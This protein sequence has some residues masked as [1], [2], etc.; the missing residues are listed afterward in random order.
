MVCS[1]HGPVSLLL[2][3]AVSLLNETSAS[4]H[5][6]RIVLRQVSPESESIFDLIIELYEVCRGDW[7]ALAEKAG[8]SRESLESFL[9]YSATFLDSLGNYRVR[10][11]SRKA[12]EE[13]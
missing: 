6:A 9:D 12:F 1:S 10:H 3:S 11:S 13:A 4:Y 5:G 8:V 2:G 7:I